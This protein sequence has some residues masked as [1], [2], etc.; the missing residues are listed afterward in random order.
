MLQAKRDV[1]FLVRERRAAQ[2]R[3]KGLRIKS[4]TGDL[5]LRDPPTVRAAQLRARFDLILLS[6]KAYDLQ[7]AINDFAPA[8]DESSAILPLLNGMHHL[9]VLDSRF[10]AHAVLGGQCLISSALDAEGQILHLNDLHSLSFG[11]RDA[12]NSDRATTILEELTGAAFEARLSPRILQEMWEKWVFIA[13]LGG[14]TC[15]M[16]ASIGDIAAAGAA[17]LAARLYGE[18]ARIAEDAGFP[19]GESMRQRSLAA[20]TTP[21]SPLTASMLRDIE[22]GGRTELDQILGDLLMRRRSSATADEVDA[23]LLSIAC[24]HLRAYENRRRGAAS[25]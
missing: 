24:A 2:L 18:C 11:E 21:G 5:E 22:S 25:G 9:Q 20:L 4:P 17:P 15:L 13:A 19:P 23:S 14:I 16:R 8:V 7:S 10:G 3:S 12:P 1:T 6:C